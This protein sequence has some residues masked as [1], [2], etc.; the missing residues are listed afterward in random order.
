LPDG[1]APRKAQSSGWFRRV[2]DNIRKNRETR[3][4]GRVKNMQDIEEKRRPWAWRRGTRSRVEARL[5]SMGH[6]YYQAEELN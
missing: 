6:P 4:A 2:V 5:R 3:Y 1:R